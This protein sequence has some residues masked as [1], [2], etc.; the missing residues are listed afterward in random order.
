MAEL[1]V[2]R[3]KIMS[4]ED[5]F[6]PQRSANSTESRVC[7]IW[8]EILELPEVSPGDDFL[9]LGG[10]SIAGTLC[11]NRIRRIFGVEFALSTLVEEAVTVQEL[12]RRIDAATPLAT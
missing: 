3:E 1:C 5:T 11:L 6:A 2:P 8:Q 4:L 7:A 12:A 10:D 9:A